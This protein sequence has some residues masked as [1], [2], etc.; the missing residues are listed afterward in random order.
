MPGDFFTV[1]S[2]TAWT[3]A[4][5]AAV[6]SHRVDG[7]PQEEPGPVLQT[8][9][10]TDGTPWTI[11]EVT[12]GDQT[13]FELKVNDGGPSTGATSCVYLD[14]VNPQHLGASISQV[15]KHSTVA[16]VLAPNGT[17]AI[18]VSSHAKHSSESVTTRSDAPI[19]AS[20]G[21]VAFLVELPV[22]ARQ[23]ANAQVAG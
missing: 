2:V 14:E 20:D 23:F 18:E 13:C 9:L 12:V 22:H 5:Y 15:G 3:D 21:S 17:Q 10:L 7:E 8:G 16:V 4:A 6:V 11:S 1:E 19:V